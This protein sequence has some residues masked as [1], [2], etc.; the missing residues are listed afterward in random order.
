[1]SYGYILYLYF[2]KKEGNQGNNK[3]SNVEKYYCTLFFIQILFC[4]CFVFVF[5]F[6]LSL[7]A[8]LGEGGMAMPRFEFKHSAI[9]E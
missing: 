7:P 9:E 6:L 2:I 3:S 1:M 5:F 8:L 4:F